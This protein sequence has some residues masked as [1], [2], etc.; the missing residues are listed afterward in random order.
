MIKYTNEEKT[1]AVFNDI[2]FSLATPDDWDSIG[3]TPTREA[4]LEWLDKGNTPSPYV[5]PAKTAT[6]FANAVQ[7]H[8]DI[9]ASERNYEGILSLATYATSTNPKF[10]AEGQAGLEWRDA[11]WA[12]CYQSL[13]DVGVGLRTPPTVEGLISELPEMVWPS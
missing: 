4:V 11:C 6:D 10:K 12:Y 13:Y 2:A 7:S 1:A 8:M 3:D 5:P 9:K